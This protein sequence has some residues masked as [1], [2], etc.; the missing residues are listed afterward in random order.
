[1]V[2]ADISGRPMCPRAVPVGRQHGADII[3][4]MT[5]PLHSLRPQRPQNT[6]TKVFWE[7][8]QPACHLKCP[9]SVPDSQSR[10]TGSLLP[11]RSAL[12]YHDGIQTPN[13]L[14]WLCLC[15]WVRLSARFAGCSL[16]LLQVVLLIL[17]SF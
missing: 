9:M 6:R 14:C 15:C 7:D 1:M 13:D 11:H 16:H 4:G 10:C 17:F 3:L 8:R 5:S 12:S 2:F